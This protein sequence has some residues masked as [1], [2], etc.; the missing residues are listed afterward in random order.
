MT[1]PRLHSKGSQCLFL[2]SRIT[3]AFYFLFL[4]IL[5]IFQLFYQN[6][7]LLGESNKKKTPL[8]RVP[9]STCPSPH[10]AGCWEAWPCSLQPGLSPSTKPYP[11][12]SL[13]PKE[14]SLAWLHAFAPPIPSSWHAHPLVP[15]WSTAPLWLQ[16]LGQRLLAHEVSWP[17]RL[18]FCAL[19]SMH[20][21]SS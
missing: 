5:C 4:L 8:Q 14:L 18:P 20:F 2:N 12:Q 9:S 21:A 13:L 6:R 16:A 1:F 11:L 10:T 7:A 17:G 15:A 3:G 19:H